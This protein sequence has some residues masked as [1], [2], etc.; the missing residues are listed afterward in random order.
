MRNQDR[1]PICSRGNNQEVYPI[2]LNAE[3]SKTT[4]PTVETQAIMSNNKK[5]CLMN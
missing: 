3:Q 2:A 1:G 5:V 4:A